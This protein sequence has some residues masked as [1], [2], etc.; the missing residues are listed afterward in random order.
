[1]EKSNAV[2]LSHRYTPV[3]GLT[4]QDALVKLRAWRR[5][6]YTAKLL[7]DLSPE[8]RLDCGIQGPEFDV[9][10]FEVPREL[11][12]RLISTR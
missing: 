3:W 7:A 8:Q 9:P 11:M 1:M 12:Q 5:R 4:L 10:T 2:R 6:R